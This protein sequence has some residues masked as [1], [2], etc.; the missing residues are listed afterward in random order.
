MHIVEVHSDMKI[1]RE[2][3]VPGDISPAAFSS[4]A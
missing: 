3:F 4:A 1:G 2:V